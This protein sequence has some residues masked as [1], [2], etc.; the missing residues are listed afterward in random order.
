MLSLSRPPAMAFIASLT[1]LM[2]GCV[3]VK[4]AGAGTYVMRNCNVPGYGSAPAG[5]WRA[6]L[7]PNAGV[8]DT[9]LTGGGLG[10]TL[11]GMLQLRTWSSL[12]LVRPTNGSQFVS[13][14]LWLATRLSGSGAPL[15]VALAGRGGGA[16]NGG[17]VIEPPGAEA[18]T[19]SHPLNPDTTDSFYVYLICSAETEIQSDCYSAHSMPLQL[20]GAEMTLNDE[21]RPT[22]AVVG[23]TLLSVGHQS[24]I[25]DVRYEGSD[26]QS[27]L[28]KV[29]AWI[30]DVLAVTRDLSAGC[31]YTDFTPC[32][33]TDTG[34]LLVDTRRVEDGSYPL[35][36]RLYD[37]AGNM[38]TIG[39]QMI[40]VSNTPSATPALAMA[41]AP[42]KTH[43]ARLS[44]R[45]AGS[46]RTTL[47][48]A[49]GK[50]VV[51]RGR[52]STSAPS[53]LANARIVVYERSARAGSREVATGSVRTR[54][55]GTF[56]Y[57]LARYGPSR[58]LRVAYRPENAA[59]ASVATRTL[60][61][62]VR[63][64]STLRASLRG[65]LVRFHGRVLSRPVP[66]GGKRVTLQGRA[67]GFAWSTFSA[68]RTDAVGRF[69]GRYRL[70]VRRPGIKL[71]I[72]V[73]LP[74]ERTYPYLS[75][76]GRP[77]TLRVR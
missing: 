13:A 53:S 50:R 19:F 12:H 54:A 36:L 49:Y 57:A 65:T 23:G 29:E 66:K 39:G 32:R 38:Q 11:N 64:A 21:V 47:S 35:T 71:E 72:R 9:C 33:S 56:A 77:I 42:T 4:Q 28:T 26:P 55:D 61:I 59:Q 63:A 34:T 52:L 27:G 17:A 7:A 15:H 75:F 8:V 44:A 60:R 41:V 10:L 40:D 20:R 51:V 25:R 74:T 62:R 58:T 6:T 14:R 48:V 18:G 24:G 67:P 73:V 2:S 70:S 22:G 46:S 16:V 30:G 37:A 76:R 68:A 3:A 45:F 43:P 1:L 69:S 31:T 5:P